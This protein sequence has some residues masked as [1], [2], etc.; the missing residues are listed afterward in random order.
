MSAPK[1]QSSPGGS[2][3]RGSLFFPHMHSHD[4][5]RVFEQLLME[6]GGLQMLISQC[7]FG[8]IYIY[9]SPLLSHWQ[10]VL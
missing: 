8:Y 9:V 10:D 2:V 4:Y 6:Y 3:R 7:P 1:G 5:L